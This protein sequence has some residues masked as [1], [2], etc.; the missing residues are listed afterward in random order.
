M[1]FELELAYI[2]KFQFPLGIFNRFGSL[3]GVI[4]DC[5]ILVSLPDPDNGTSVKLPILIFLFKS[6]APVAPVI[7]PVILLLK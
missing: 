3:I 1:L 2:S 7:D 4:K 6:R 5:I